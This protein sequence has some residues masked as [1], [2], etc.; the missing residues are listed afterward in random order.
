MKYAADYHVELLEFGSHA[1]A[2]IITRWI[3]LGTG[4]SPDDPQWKRA[5]SAYEKP[6]S[7]DGKGLA[8][9]RVAAENVVP[10]HWSKE[11]LTFSN[12][13]LLRNSE[14]Q[15]LMEELDYD[16]DIWILPTPRKA[17]INPYTEKIKRIL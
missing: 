7:L 15:N 9:P 3:N 1:L 2:L 14:Y 10:S 12:I 6:P 13:S 5:Q 11:A 8:S 16:S 4:S 17:S